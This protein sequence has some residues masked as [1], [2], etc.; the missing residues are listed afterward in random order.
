MAANPPDPRIPAPRL[1][2]DITTTC[3]P[4]LWRVTANARGSVLGN[5]F[6]FTDH[7][8]NRFVTAQEC[9]RGK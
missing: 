8:I 1:T 6:D 3:V 5:P 7:S 9:T 4:G 2:Y